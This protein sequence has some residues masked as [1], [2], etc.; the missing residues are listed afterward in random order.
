MVGCYG[1]RGRVGI[2]WIEHRLGIRH[3]N[4]P[5]AW[6]SAEPEVKI[7]LGDWKQMGAMGMA[8]CQRSLVD[9]DQTKLEVMVKLTQ[10]ARDRTSLW[11]TKPGKA[12]KDE[13]TSRPGKEVAFNW[14]R[15]SQKA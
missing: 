3:K 8:V 6:K 7:D 15:K 1:N 14:K 11:S 13:A 5:E 10:I 9:R 12:E 4:V 2:S